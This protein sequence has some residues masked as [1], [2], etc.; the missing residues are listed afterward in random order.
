MHEAL[1][2]RRGGLGPCDFEPRLQ[3]V[4]GEVAGLA[5][6][7]LPA[8]LAHFDCRNNRLA[9]LALEADGFADAV[10]TARERYGAARIGVM[11]GTSTSGIHQTEL[12]YQRR[13]PE[14][15]ALPADFQ[16]EF[17]HDLL[18][19]TRFVRE[20][21]Q[22]RGP[23]AMVSTA[24]SSS[25]KVF[26]SAWRL[27]TTG[28][29]DAVV[30]GG[31]DSLCLNTLYGFSSLELVSDE[32]TTPCAADRKGI[33]IGEAAGF[34]LLEWPERAVDAGSGIVLLGY[35]ESSDAYHMSTPRPDGEGAALAMARALERASLKGS[36]IDYINMHG[37]ASQVN[38]A[39]EDKAISRVCGTDTAASSTKGWTGHTLGAAGITE[40]AIAFA[41]IT[42]QFRPGTLN[43]KAVDPSFTSRI[44]LDN[45][46]GTVRRVLS[47]SFGF[48]G[49]N[50]ALVFGVA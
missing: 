32:A 5:D 46:T 37:T 49:S 4:V 14:T 42:H 43:T 12:A 16:F 30:V 45:E 7:A 2:N 10:A 25:A 8:A 48:G 39:M 21:L 50:C 47:N 19:S 27:M 28:V 34:A 26:A 22:L 35:G 31:V 33:N 24:C 36:D 11:L 3:T 40:A 13:D 29:C 20:A 17:T 41:A 44:L 15:G 9:Q 1:A 23:Q 18:A 6:V 38:D